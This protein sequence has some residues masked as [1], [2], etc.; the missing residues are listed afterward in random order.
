MVL[1]DL[2]VD[3]PDVAGALLGSDAPSARASVVRWAHSLGTLHASTS[4]WSPRMTASLA[5]HADRLGQAVPAVDDMPAA[6][7]R[8]ADAWA[9]LVG[10]L[11]IN[12]DARALDQ[13]REIDALLGGGVDVRALTPSDACPDNNLLRDHGMVLL[14]FEGAQVRHMAWDVAY[15]RVPWPSCWCCWA[16]PP[17]V[18]DAGVGAWQSAVLSTT[19]YVGTPGFAHDVDLAVAGWAVVS[20]A[21]F[22]EG[23]L[24]GKQDMDRR[25]P[26]RRAVLLNRL[27]Q[28]VAVADQRLSAVQDVAAQLLSLLRGRWG[29]QVLPLAPALRR[30]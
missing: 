26:A 7:D 9:Q 29:D 14:D 4:G 3:L 27:H 22:L 28:L 1:E 13:I 5:L 20:V 2:G 30:Q 25:T 15:L 12:V 21:W 11:R 23:A 17:E 16:L 19:P 10:P 18:A 6:L 24:R 8:A